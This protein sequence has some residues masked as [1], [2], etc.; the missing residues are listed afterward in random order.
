M[1][2]N[3]FCGIAR[4]S[5]VSTLL[6]LACVTA[7]STVTPSLQVGDVISPATDGDI[8]MLKKV[9]I[10]PLHIT[11]GGTSPFAGV[12]PAALEAKC[13]D[14][15]DL[16]HLGPESACSLHYSFTTQHLGHSL[17]A[18]ICVESFAKR[19]G[20]CA[21]DILFKNQRLT[22]RLVRADDDALAYITQSIFSVDRAHWEQLPSI[23]IG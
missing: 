7:C 21:G 14:W 20:P 3:S 4:K 2:L 16:N 22:L 15:E 9:G 18:E 1:R 8:A 19:S 11:I 23:Q 17:N 5:V 12:R 10:E 6:T 13:D